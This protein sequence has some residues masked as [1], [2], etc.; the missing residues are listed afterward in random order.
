MIK[1]SE[2]LQSCAD[3]V[4]QGARLA[5]VGCD[6]GYA[7]V[8]LAEKNLIKSAV[9][10]DIN[11]KPLVSCKS[12]VKEYGFE[13]IIKCVISDGLDNIKEDEVDDILIAGMGGELIASILSKCSYVK[14][15]HLVLNPMTHPEL[16]RKW[17]F[18]NGFEIKNDIIVSDSNHHYSVFD[19]Y[20]TGEFKPFGDK[21]IF[22]GKINDFSDKEYFMH[23]LNYLKNKEKGGADCYAVI[24]EIERKIK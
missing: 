6:H 23:L 11:E 14:E 13:D 15:K 1:L 7:V 16:A 3:L 17:L 10:C 22:L 5:D 21:E 12:L 2:R 24:S 9:A 4:R 19:A 18:E 8:S 20:Y